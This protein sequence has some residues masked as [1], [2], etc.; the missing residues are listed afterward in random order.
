M[1]QRKHYAA[2]I[3]C[4]VTATR[5]KASTADIYKAVRESGAHG[6]IVQEQGAA[7]TQDDWKHT[8][9]NAMQF[10]KRKGVIRYLRDGVWGL[11]VADWMTWL[12]ERG[13]EE[14]PSAQAASAANEWL[15]A[16]Q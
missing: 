6:Q 12:S 4:L 10:L 5:H 3:E 16:Q 14:G 9:R 7:E 8:V 15:H 2:I 11:G 13:L 1:S